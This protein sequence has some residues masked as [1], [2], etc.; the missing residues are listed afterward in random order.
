MPQLQT[1]V[2]CFIALLLVWTSVETQAELGDNVWPR[3]TSFVVRSATNETVRIGLSPF[4]ASMHYCEGCSESTVLKQAVSR[5][6]AYPN[7]LC[8][9]FTLPS[10]QLTST[11]SDEGHPYIKKI[12]MNMP[13]LD[14]QHAQPTNGIGFDQQ[15]VEVPLL[16]TDDS[17]T[18]RLNSSNAGRTYSL[19]VA[20][21]TVFGLVRALETLTQLTSFDDSQT[22]FAYAINVNLETNEDRNATNLTS[23]AAF[24][25]AIDDAPAYS[26]RG[27]RISSARQY[28]SVKA[29]KRVIDGLAAAKMNVLQWQLFDAEVFPLPR[30]GLDTDSYNN[31][32]SNSLFAVPWSYSL[33]DLQSVVAYA[34]NRAV[35]VVPE[36]PV[37]TNNYAWAAPQQLEANC[38]IASATCGTECVAIDPTLPTTFTAIAQLISSL[39]TAFPPSTTVWHF[40]GFPLPLDCWAED[41]RLATI[42]ASSEQ[43]FANH[44]APQF[45][46]LLARLNLTAMAADG[47]LL[48][49]VRGVQVAH[50]IASAAA[51]SG[52]ALSLVRSDMWRLDGDASSSRASDWQSVYARSPAA[53]CSPG[54]LGNSGC[55]SGVS[56]LGVEAYVD[57]EFVDDTT[58]DQTLWPRTAALAE[59]LWT[60]NADVSINQASLRLD[61]FRCAV[62]RRRGIAALPVGPRSPA[63]LLPSDQVVAATDGSSSSRSWSMLYDP[64]TLLLEL[65]AW[66]TLLYA[67]YRS[68]VW[69]DLLDAVFEKDRPATSAGRTPIERQPEQG[70][71]SLRMAIVLPIFGSLV[72]IILFYFLDWMSYLFVFFIFLSSLFSLTFVLTPTAER[73]VARAPERAQMPFAPYQSLPAVLRETSLSLLLAFLT[74]LAVALTWLITRYWAV[75]D[76]VA[77]C[78]VISSLSG[79][80]LPNL[81][82]ATVVLSLFF[83]YDIFWVFLSSCLFGKNVM[84]SVAVSLPSLPILITLPK[85]LSSGST[86]LGLGDLILPGLLL[87]YL[88]RF[89]SKNFTPSLRSLFTDCQG[90]FWPAFGGYIV[91]LE[92]ALVMLLTFQSAQPALL[93]LVPGTLI[94]TFALSWYR[95]HLR[96]LWKGRS[97]SDLP[98]AS[99]D[100]EGDSDTQPMLAP[101]RGDIDEELDEARSQQDEL[102]DTLPGSEDIDGEIN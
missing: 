21:P 17:Y 53:A 67:T 23:A 18:I 43:L 32:N 1:R 7:G 50:R 78:F 26:W 51:P 8:F 13:P 65:L 20:A 58:I 95:G 62:L 86:M 36:L 47:S 96:A 63:C 37:L 59:R 99:R 29:V 84:V 98:A 101:D 6:L 19:Y 11:I 100:L 68:R 80:R 35:V 77:L 72:L 66:S 2:W 16:T 83:F 27:V 94:P 54:D 31:N 97:L 91:G 15:G 52:Q 49:S 44:F 33:A 92:T 25:L 60:G 79:M 38:P 34:R 82:V 89:D 87:C 90:Y 76:V 30:A 10:S 71:I 40:G 102:D 39:S 74:A 56:L 88:Y 73:L 70:F 3:P 28:L 57:G 61:N 48:A 81:K 22:P 14:Q 41:Q 55:G 12:W 5:Y 45:A 9:P 24:E 93:Y 42:D 46:E 85:V 69:S 64:S 75:S 4:V